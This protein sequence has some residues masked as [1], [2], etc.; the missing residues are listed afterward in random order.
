MYDNRVNMIT[1][2]IPDQH[3][4]N[5]MKRLLLV[6][7]LVLCT[8]TVYGFQKDG[9]GSGNCVDCHSLS[10]EEAA[11]L[12]KGKVDNV[13]SVKISEVP[14]LWVLEAV[15]QGKTIPI[16]LDFS[17]KY[18]FSGNVIRLQ[19]GENL[20][21][22]PPVETVDVSVIPL[23]D[24]VVLGNPKA[25]KKIIVFDDPECPFCQK[26]HHEMEEIAKNRKD[27]AFFIKMFP[28]KSHPHSYEKAKT[29]ICTKSAKLL[30]DSLAGQPL[31][32]PVCETDQVEKNIELAEKLHIN[33]T[34]TLIFPDGKVF[35]GYRPADA[36]L[37]ILEKN[38]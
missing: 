1:G 19:D 34:P 12:L 17:K 8:S 21:P 5:G 25:S 13:V 22:P 3:R 29:I 2:L 16:Y 18:I 20:T 27:I 26:L 14:G 4:G 32:P 28:L 38:K 15:Y 9:C 36:I 24:A 30:A 37:S 6:L 31:P 23:E 33:S 7:G 35:P 10:R 11:A